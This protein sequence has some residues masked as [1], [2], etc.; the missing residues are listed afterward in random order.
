MHI[1]ARKQFK[2]AVHFRGDSKRVKTI[3]SPAAGCNTAEK[4]KVMQPARLRPRGQTDF[5]A[6]VNAELMLLLQPKQ[7]GALL[8]I[9]RVPTC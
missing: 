6:K 1:I 7:V 5:I 2:I 9:S 8:M 4:E 3:K